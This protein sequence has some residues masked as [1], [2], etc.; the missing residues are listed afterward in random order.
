MPKFPTNQPFRIIHEQQCLIEQMHEA[1]KAFDA[2]LLAL[3]ADKIEK[4]VQ[5]R[6]TD[7]QSDR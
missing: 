5:V 1:Y 7:R 2:Q 4:E 6:Q 3:R